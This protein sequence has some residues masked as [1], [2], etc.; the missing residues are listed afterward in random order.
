MAWHNP[1][2]QSTKPAQWVEQTGTST[3][4]V[5]KHNSLCVRKHL[6]LLRSHTQART[7][8]CFV[9]LVFCFIFLAS[10]MQVG[11][12][13][14]CKS[15]CCL[16]LCSLTHAL[17]WALTYADGTMLGEVVGLLAISSW[18]LSP[19]QRG[20]H[21]HCSEKSSWPTTVPRQVS[22]PF[23]FPSLCQST[24]IR[25]VGPREAVPTRDQ[26]IPEA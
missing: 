16:I 6:E 15:L 14:M 9:S 2:G 13:C 1:Y 5:A 26:P 22:L 21:H 18:A 17:T 7:S 4:S 24:E 8:L 20:D 10:V 3:R 25:A 12:K 23:A 11:L 19:Y